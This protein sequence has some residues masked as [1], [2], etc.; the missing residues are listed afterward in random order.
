MRI[1][2]RV[3]DEETNGLLLLPPPPTLPVFLCGPSAQIVHQATIITDRH[4]RTY[5]EQEEGSVR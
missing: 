4:Y 3:S 1:L 2:K 5:Y